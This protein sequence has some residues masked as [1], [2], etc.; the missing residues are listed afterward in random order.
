MRNPRH[1]SASCLAAVLVIGMIGAGAAQ[2]HTTATYEAWVLECDVQTGPPVQKTCDIAQTQVA[3]VQGRNSPVS[4]VAIR[5]PVKGQPVRLE[6][7][8]PVNISFTANVRIQTSDSDPGVAGPFARCLPA[9]CFADL[10]LRDDVI[11]KFRAANENGKMT[12]RSAAGQ[13]VSIPVSFKGFGAAFDALVK[14]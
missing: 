1:Q 10:D 6:L 5:R 13:D 4:H 2:E 7:Q 3:Q 12:F 9:G 11:K 14:E 8:V